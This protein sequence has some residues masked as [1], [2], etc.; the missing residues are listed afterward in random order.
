M[1]KHPDPYYKA[2]RGHQKHKLDKHDMCQAEWMINLGQAHDGADVQHALFPQVLCA[3]VCQRLNKYGLEGYVQA[4]KPY[5]N[6]RHMWGQRELVEEFVGREEKDL[7][8]SGVLQWVKIQ[9]FWLRQ[10]EVLP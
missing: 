5:L 7:G 9:S 3:T 1:D 2:P 10:E 4:E 8:C 6:V